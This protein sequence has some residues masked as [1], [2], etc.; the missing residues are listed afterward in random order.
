MPIKFNLRCAFLSTWE[1]GGYSYNFKIKFLDVI[2]WAYATS[3]IQPQRVLVSKIGF[4]VIDGTHHHRVLHD[5]NFIAW[6]LWDSKA[7]ANATCVILCLFVFPPFLF[8]K[9]K[10]L[11]TPVVPW[12]FR[13]WGL[14]LYLEDNIW[15]VKDL[16]RL[17]NI[18][19]RDD[20]AL[21][22][23]FEEYS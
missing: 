22:E 7:R 16:E 2:M 23:E 1:G 6:Q 19:L 11:Q 9:L 4:L 20:V 21:V 18:V 12:R 10:A 13:T 5:K 3:M 17:A 14:V 8:N 15:E